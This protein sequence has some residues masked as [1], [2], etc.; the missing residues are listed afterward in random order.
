[1]SKKLNEA[2]RIGRNDL[3]ERL[4]H[5]VPVVN[6]DVSTIIPLRD[7][8]AIRHLA[9]MRKDF[10]EALVKAIPLRNEAMDQLYADSE[11]EVY[12]IEPQGMDIGQTFIL[13]SKVLGIMSDMNSIF[14]DFATKGL[15]K[16]PPSIIYGLDRQSQ[17]AIAFY[18]PPL[19]EHHNSD[20]VLLDGIHRSYICKS[21]GTTVTA[22]HVFNA[23]SPLPFDKIEWGEAQLME[24]KP[25]I[26]QRYRNLNPKLFRDLGYVG[27]D[28]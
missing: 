12:G 22:V 23:A 3:E 1:M 13:S 19:I 20:G 8:V 27:I 2:F 25:P 16:M 7:I 17:S 26:E 5:K 15:S 4:Q 21:A 14:G 18:V 28:G 11:I 6:S 24:N 9:I 10:L